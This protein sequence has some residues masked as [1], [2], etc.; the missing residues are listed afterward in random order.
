MN[1][2][3]PKANIITKL[4]EDIDYKQNINYRLSHYTIEKT[5]PHGTLLYNTLSCELILLNNEEA[6]IL[7]KLPCPVPDCQ[8]ELVEA[9]FL[10]PSDCDETRYCN[11]LKSKLHLLTWEE[12]IT[13]YYTIFTTMDCNARCFYC[14]ELGREHTYMTEETAKETADY[15]VSHCKGKPVGLSWFG[16]EPLLNYNVIDIIINELKRRNIT[17]SSEMLTNG[18]LFDD[19]LIQKAKNDWNLDEIQITLD[20]TEEIYNKRKAYIYREGNPYRRV[21][22]NIGKCLA[23]GFTVSIRLNVDSKN[24]ADMYMLIDEL[25]NTFPE[26]NKPFLYTHPIFDSFGENISNEKYKK[27]LKICYALTAHIHDLGLARNTLPE[28]VPLRNCIAENDRG[29]T[30]TPDGFLGKC[31]HYTAEE[32]MIG[33]I[34]SDKK[35]AEKIQHWK[36]KFPMLPECLSCFYYPQCIRL[37]NCPFIP[38]FCDAEC[39]EN[40]KLKLQQLMILAYDEWQTSKSSGTD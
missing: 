30:I 7:A 2:I 9:L 10:V 17:Y 8:K 26:T 23:A 6:A 29:I 12:D 25:A 36:E 32:Y 38:S 3:Q 40:T 18:Y 13:E 1:V 4:I 35:D 31:E 27:L 14:F 15:I 28:I 16:G 34:R 5:T 11:Q 20:G 24:E 22:S 21:I 37:K 39:Q 33:D 19:L